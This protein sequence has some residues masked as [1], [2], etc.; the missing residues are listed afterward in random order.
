LKHLRKNGCFALGIGLES[1]IPKNLENYNKQYK[2]TS[3]SKLIKTI[4]STGIA[5]YG[6]FMFGGEHD[7]KHTFSETCDYILKNKIDLIQFTLLTPYPGTPLYKNLSNNN[8]IISRDWEL[9]DSLTNVVFKPKNLTVDELEEGIRYAYN[10][11]YSIKSIFKR[12]SFFN[13]YF[14]YMLIANIG[15]RQTFVSK[16]RN[17]EKS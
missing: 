2:P 9:Y 4:K 3:Y 15:Y 10:R 6:L 12:T 1:I 7:T 13:K 5:V 14:I 17:N 8:R 11:I 16:Y